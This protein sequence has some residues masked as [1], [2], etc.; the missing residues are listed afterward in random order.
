MSKCMGSADFRAWHMISAQV[1]II[2][3]IISVICNHRSS[4]LLLTE[5][6]K[7]RS[8]DVARE[9]R[10]QIDGGGLLNDNT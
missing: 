4:S 6:E 3:F 7:S 5:H 9:Q 2:I 8:Q 1:E 10:R